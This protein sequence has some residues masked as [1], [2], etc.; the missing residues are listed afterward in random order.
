M[1]DDSEFITP[2]PWVAAAPPPNATEDD[3]PAQADSITLP[4]DI[5]DSATHRL[6]QERQRTPP[7][8]PEIVFFPTV[9]GPVRPVPEET[10]VEQPLA[11]TEPEPDAVS[12]ETVHVE[13]H[14]RSWRI[15]MQGSPPILVSSTL[16]LGRNPTPTPG[17]E[18]S[19]VFALDDATKSISKTHA[20]LEVDGD[21]LWVHDLNSTNGVWIITEG[22]EPLGVVPGERA[23]VPAGS[24]LEL[25]DVVIQVE[26]G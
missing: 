9:A 15:V 6:S 19:P 20:M 16:F 4:P 1:S 8:K 22:E 2:P 18:R 21:T 14:A 13:R 11:P 25:G 10:L 17:H 3:A 7:P 24:D 26:H 12:D 23:Q 5:A